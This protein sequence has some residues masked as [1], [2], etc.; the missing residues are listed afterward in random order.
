MPLN[1]KDP[2]A[3]RLATEIAAITGESKTRAIR[4]ALEERKERLAFRVAP[5]DRGAELTRLLEEEIWPTVPPGALG[6]RITK[7]QRERILGY[8]PEGV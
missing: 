5:L 7:R 8:G 6:K 3:V 2:L 4:V 1:L